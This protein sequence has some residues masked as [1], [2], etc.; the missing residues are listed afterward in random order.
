MAGNGRINPGDYGRINL[1]FAKQ[2]IVIPRGGPRTC[3][4]ATEYCNFKTGQLLI[5]VSLTLSSF[6]KRPST[7]RSG[8]P[9]DIF[10]TSSRVFPRIPLKVYKK[11][12]V[13]GNE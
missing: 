7:Q 2:L 5:T 11:I 12:L 9:I 13:I 10:L 4:A 6:A 1:A 3:I 8:S